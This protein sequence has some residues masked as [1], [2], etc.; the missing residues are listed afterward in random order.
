VAG[1][2]DGN[3]RERQA[4]SKIISPGL[5]DPSPVHD[6]EASEIGGGGKT[7]VVMMKQSRERSPRAGLLPLCHFEEHGTLRFK[8]QPER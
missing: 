2:G 5:S 3:F 6:L 4:L 8:R 1:P 7:L